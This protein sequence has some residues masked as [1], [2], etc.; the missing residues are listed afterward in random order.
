[1]RQFLDIHK[2]YLYMSISDQALGEP[3]SSLRWT[4]PAL[5]GAGQTMGGNNWPTSSPQDSQMPPLT[6]V[7][8]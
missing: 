3:E 6:V 4:R 2:N 7:R 5:E 8:F 1:M